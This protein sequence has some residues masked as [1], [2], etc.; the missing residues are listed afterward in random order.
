MGPAPVVTALWLVRHGATEWSLAGRFQ[1]WTDVPLAPAGRAQAERLRERMSSISFTSVLSS[2]LSRAVETARIAVGEPVVDARLRELDFG[3]LEGSRWE[4]CSIEIREALVRFRGFRAPGGESV[5]DLEVRVNVALRELPA[6]EH[7]VFTH[8]G[9]IR[10]LLRRR[11]RLDD[12]AP[13]ELVRVDLGKIGGGGL[14]GRR[15]RRRRGKGEGD[16]RAATGE[17]LGP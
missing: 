4:D 2:D 15:L 17:R 7:A 11:G 8:G 9:V 6:G 16:P 3:S 14:G 12:V 10:L 5:D 1:G 13:G